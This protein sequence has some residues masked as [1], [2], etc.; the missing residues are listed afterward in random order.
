[1][2]KIF[3]IF[4]FCS[5]FLYAQGIYFSEPTSSHVDYIYAS[6]QGPI[7]YNFYH[8]NDIIVYQ[9]YARLKYPDGS[10]SSWNAGTDAGETGGWWVSKEGT[11][12]IEGKAYVQNIF[13]GG[14][15]W[16]ER[17][18]FSFSVVDNYSPSI[19]TNFSGN[20]VSG[21]P[22][23]SWSANTE[24]D[25][26]G[27]V[28]DR[29]DGSWEYG[30]VTTSLTAYTDYDVDIN[31]MFE[32]IIKYRIRSKDINNNYSNYTSE[33]QF[34][35]A[36]L[37]KNNHNYIQVS[38][39]VDEFKLNSVYPNPFNPSTNILYS[40]PEPEFVNLAVFDMLGKQVEV[41]VNQYMEAG[42]HS[43][44]FNANNIAAGTYIVMMRAGTYTKS[45]KI[46][47][48]K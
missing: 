29:W 17:S 7:Q 40:L 34:T 14:P 3:F 37:H 36:V 11:Y 32:D 4:A 22:V 25:L 39:K 8:A 18:P 6:G 26:E 28:I 20:V 35:D 45:E 24:A 1:M 21:H 16:A 38:V 5:S 15:Y 47:L 27:Y 23:L 2:K 41:L 44:S 31:P 13:Y 19:P 43:V 9:Y 33:V 12:Q 30:I 42:I 48:V 46:L 10:Y